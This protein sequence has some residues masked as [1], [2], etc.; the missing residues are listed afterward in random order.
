MIC[1]DD[2]GAIE[3]LAREIS[4]AMR[5]S[6][7]D[8]TLGNRN[9]SDIQLKYVPVCHVASLY[10]RQLKCSIKCQLYTPAQ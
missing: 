1:D 4:A 5:R 2:D 9:R 7:V 3:H 6:G 10:R 8:V